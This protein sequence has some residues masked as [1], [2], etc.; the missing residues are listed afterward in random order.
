MEPLAKAGVPLLHVYGDADEVVPWE[1][2]TGLLAERYRALGGS[3]Q[4]I[5][6]PGVRHHPHGLEDSTPI[7]DFILK[8][9]P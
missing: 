2:N 1:E 5:G 4:L 9:S 3:I 7:I 8:N 6:K